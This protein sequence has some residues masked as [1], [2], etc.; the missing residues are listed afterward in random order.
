[1]PFGSI[2][3]AARGLALKLAARA[4]ERRLNDDRSDYVGP[5]CPCPHCGQPARFVGR[6]FK[7]FR[8][9][10]GDL[11]LGRT[12]YS[13]DPCG[14]GF[15]PRDKALGLD[16]LSLSPALLRMV[17]LVGATVSFEEGSELVSELAGVPVD[18]KLVE[19]EAEALGAEIAVDERQVVE[20]ETWRPLPPTMYLGLDG[21]GVPMRTAEVEGRAGKQEDGSAK[22]RE[23]KLCVT[24]T[25]E[26][27][28]KNGVPTRDPGSVTYSAAI[29]SAAM[30]DTDD[31]L[32]DVAQRLSR[33][34]QR[35]RFLDVPRRVVLGDGAAFIWNTFDELF[36]GAIQILDRFHAKQHLVDAA[37]A[38]W[39]A[40]NDARHGWLAARMT[41][42][43]DGNV[44]ALVERLMVHA[45][46]CKE[47]SD[48]A[49]YFLRNRHRMRYAEFRA[50][51]LC[52]STGVVEAGCK[53]T[54]GTRLKRPGMHWT[55]RGANAI[56]A[57]RCAK[58]SNR[59]DPFLDRR[60]ALPRAA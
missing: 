21:T 29:E 10:L 43:D 36:P 22:T 38:I 24:W 54:I 35:R 53:N 34:A 6:R 32:S 17:A 12:Y 55:V 47:A 45:G 26:S 5:T 7:S 2:E 51:G 23:V 25:A 31:Q 58:L 46:H 52:T 37:K 13:C 41:E 28:D 59:L 16:G 1:M 15:C 49:A 11:R 8:T 4:V 48:C 50:A 44:E 27:R 39:T 18:A 14:W 40:D 56:I 19:R 42:L 9:A 60:S 20:Q 3:M 33:E 57:L 30:C